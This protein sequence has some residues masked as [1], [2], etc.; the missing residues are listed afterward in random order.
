MRPFAFRVSSEVGWMSVP[1]PLSGST[2]RLESS[3]DDRSCGGRD[4]SGGQILK[5]SR[6]WQ[7]SG[8]AQ[9]PH[10]GDRAADDQVFRHERIVAF[11]GPRL[12]VIQVAP[13]VA[14]LFAIVAHHEQPVSGHDYVE[15][16]SRRLCCT[17]VCR[18]GKVGRFVE[19]LVIH[20]Y[21]T[22]IIATHDVIA[23]QADGPLDQV[24][25][26]GVRKYANELEGL[27]DGTA[28][29][30]LGPRQPAT[31][32]AEHDNLTAFQR[33]QLLDQNPVVDMESVLH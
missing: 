12:H 5:S 25:G 24:L 20:A 16:D 8:V 6:C 17:A 31:R 13:R 7:R 9:R 14:A 22:L 2:V 11:L 3:I 28:A 18:D 10:N 15:P 26:T 21:S 4:L 27:A 30:R 1:S 32:V 33:A 29:L 23:R 19:W